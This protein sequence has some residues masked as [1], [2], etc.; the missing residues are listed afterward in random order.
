MNLTTEEFEAAK[1]ALSREIELNDLKGQLLRLQTRLNSDKRQYENSIKLSYAET[2]LRGIKTLCQSTF[3]LFYA[4]VTDDQ[5]FNTIVKYRGE[6]KQRF[7]PAQTPE[8]VSSRKVSLDHKQGDE[9]DHADTKEKMEEENQS[10]VVELYYKYKM[11]SRYFN[12]LYSAK[13]TITKKNHDGYS[14]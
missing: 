10:N 3:G 9:K 2:A 4:F 6:L 1:L 11:S 12:E 7:A 8:E 13:Y 5:L 14:F